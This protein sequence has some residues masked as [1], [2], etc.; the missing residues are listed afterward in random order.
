MLFGIGDNIFKKRDVHDFCGRIV[1]IADDQYLGS[2]PGLSGGMHQIVKKITAMTFGYTP[3]VSAGDN[4]RVGM[5]GI[6]GVR[7]EYHISGTYGNKDKVGDPFFGADG[8]DGFGIGIDIHI[9][10][11]F[12]PA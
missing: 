7:C 10:P 11:A 2:G 12:I 1:R 3:Y 8:G 5:D 6:G 9:I 4:C